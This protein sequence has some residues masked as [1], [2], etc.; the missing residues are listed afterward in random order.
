M[1]EALPDKMAL[2]L[3]EDSETATEA[4]KHVPQLDPDDSTGDDELSPCSSPPPLNKSVSF[5][6][7][8]TSRAQ[9]RA[10]AEKLSRE[11]K[12]ATALALVE[13]ED[14]LT[15][16]ASNIEDR[17]T[18]EAQ[19]DKVSG[20]TDLKSLIDAKKQ[21]ALANNKPKIA[22]RVEELYQRSL[23]DSRLTALLESSLRSDANPKQQIE[24]QKYIDGTR[25]TAGVPRD[26]AP[27]S[28]IAKEQNNTMRDTQPPSN[29]TPAEATTV[30]TAETQPADSSTPD[31]LTAFCVTE[32]W[33]RYC[34]LPP[35]R[36]TPVEFEAATATTVNDRGQSM[37]CHEA[38]ETW[39][40]RA[41]TELSHVLP[42][43]RADRSAL[44]Q[45]LMAE[46]G[47]KCQDVHALLAEEVVWVVH[48]GPYKQRQTRGEICLLLECVGI[49]TKGT[50][51]MS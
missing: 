50:L 48:H 9:K 32:L 40:E 7:F 25:T 8:A 28:S 37:P 13:S 41:L 20:L 38:P 43:A 33:P 49:E 31:P 10:M 4:W 17:H 34:R 2:H 14:S 42:V 1:K 29:G 24:L 12:A 36:G 18:E 45:R 51:W 44:I 3:D 30:A 35:G 5:K 23:H 47:Y 27:K 21:K 15:G 46:P 22:E 16:L 6:P 11:K 26:A 39:V 19:N